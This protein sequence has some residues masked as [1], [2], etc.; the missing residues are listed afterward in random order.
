M[1]E[2]CKEEYKLNLSVQRSDIQR[3]AKECLL[4]CKKALIAA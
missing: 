4:G 2:I 3:V 1:D